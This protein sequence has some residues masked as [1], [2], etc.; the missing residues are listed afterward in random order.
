LDLPAT[1]TEV[2]SLSYSFTMLQR[3]SILAL[4]LGF[5]TFAVASCGTIEN[6]IESGDAIHGAKSAKSG[7]PK[8]GTTAPSVSGTGVVRVLVNA[9][10]LTY[11]GIETAAGVRYEV[12]N[13]PSSLFVDGQTVNFSAFVLTDYTMGNGYGQA[14]LLSSIVAA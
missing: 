10:G 9:N 12:L 6:P 14:I 3:N 2:K 13:F 11:Y 5:V 1:P 4:A 7:G 8:K